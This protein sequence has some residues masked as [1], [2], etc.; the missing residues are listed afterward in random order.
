M[1]TRVKMVIPP[2]WC[3]RARSRSYKQSVHKVKCDSS[4]GSL[5]SNIE[6]LLGSSGVP[7]RILRHI[8]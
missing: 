5:V 3:A 7:H 8:V 6:C 1:M 2:W 4:K